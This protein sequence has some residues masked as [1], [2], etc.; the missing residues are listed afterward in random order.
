MVEVAVGSGVG[1]VV[2][3]PGARVA[4]GPA[5]RKGVGVAVA[6]G[7]G[8]TTRC[9][10][11]CGPCVAPRLIPGKL[12]AIAVRAKIS[13]KNKILFIN[14]SFLNSFSLDRFKMECGLV[15]GSRCPSWWEVV[16]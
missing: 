1:S 3:S 10:I 12:Q 8:V 6:S 9:E 13:K 5:G 7:S 2:G 16:S 11:A 14:Q 4:V 15:W